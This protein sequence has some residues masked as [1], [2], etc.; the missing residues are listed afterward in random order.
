MGKWQALLRLLLLLLLLLLLPLPLLGRGALF[1][2]ATTH[3]QDR[4]RFVGVSGPV[5]CNGT[6]FGAWFLLLLLGGRRRDG[7]LEAGRLPWWQGQQRSRCC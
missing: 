3:E 4:D 5:G 1:A 2:L 7:T 6:F